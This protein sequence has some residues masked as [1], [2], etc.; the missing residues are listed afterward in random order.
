MSEL[1]K[2]LRQADLSTVKPKTALEETFIEEP[3]SLPVFLKDK[4]F[5]HLD[6]SL[7]DIQYKV[8]QLMERVYFDG[9]SIEDGE[10]VYDPEKDLYAKMGG[11]FDPYWKIKVPMVNKIVL[12]WGHTR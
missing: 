6:I 12:Q 11:E 9:R 4:K 3:V 8:L 10:M 7:S 5:L 1:A 2:M